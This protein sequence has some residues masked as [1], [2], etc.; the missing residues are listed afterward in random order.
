ME[1][2]LLNLIVA[3]GRY[4]SI[5][6]KAIDKLG[7]QGRPINMPSSYHENRVTRDKSDHYHITFAHP[8]ELAVY[9]SN[10]GIPKKEQYSHLNTLVAELI[11]IFGDPETDWELPVDLGLGRLEQQKEDPP[12]SNKNKTKGKQKKDSNGNNTDVTPNDTTNA[13]TNSDKDATITDTAPTTTLYTSYFRV[14][15]WPFGQKVRAHLGLP[16]TSFHIT[17]GFDPKDVHAPKGP[18]TILLAPS[19]QQDP[20]LLT[21]WIASAVDYPDEK[22]FL[23][24]LSHHLIQVN[25]GHLAEPWIH[26]IKSPQ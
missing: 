10:K 6:G 25:L 21:R 2:T 3:D 13:T 9:L 4:L 15:H 24:Q 19:L 12:P 20:N 14:I 11:T 7:E 17:V 18:D 22:V 26:H 1:T 23:Q 5:V 16:P 8:R